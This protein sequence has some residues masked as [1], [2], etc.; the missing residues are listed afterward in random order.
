MKLVEPSTGLTFYTGAFCVLVI[1]AF[2]FLAYA[3]SF[4]VPFL[5]DD[6]NNILDNSTIRDLKDIGRVF[7][8]P[9]SS[10]LGQRPIVNLTLAVNYAMSGEKVWS[11]HLF[12]LLIHTV[13]ALALFGI[14][15]RTLLTERMRDDYHHVAVPLALGSSLIWMLHPVQTQAV[16]YIIQRCE[17]LMGMFFLLTVYCAIRNW[18]SPSKNRWRLLSLISFFLG[19]GSK[20]VIV[21]APFIVLAYEWYF[22]RPATMDILKHSWPLYTGY[23][24]GIVVLAYLVLTGGTLSTGMS[25]DVSEPWLYWQTQPQVIIHYLRIALWPDSLCFDYGWPLVSFREG[26]PTI[27]FLMIILA[28]TFWLFVRRKPA[29]FL[30]FFFFACLIPTSIMPLPDPVFDYRIYLSM[31]A[32][33]AAALIGIHKLCLELNKKI[34][35][36]TKRH[37]LTVCLAVF[38]ILSG[39][40]GLLT[41]KRNQVYSSELTIWTDTVLKRPQ[42]ARAQLN[43]GMA[44]DN[45]GRIHEA[46]RC[47]HEA[48][49][50]NPEYAGA[51]A[52]L[53][54]AL[55]K[56][57][58][59]KEAQVHLGR[60]LEL[61]PNKK[62]S[63]TVY[64]NMGVALSAQGL[65][66]EAIY[67]FKKAVD[68]DADNAVLM[69]N[70]GFAL[71]KTGELAGALNAY[72]KAL[73]IKPEWHLPRQRIETIRL[74][75]KGAGM[76]GTPAPVNPISDRIKVSMLRSFH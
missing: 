11:Y 27:L 74:K 64:S 13:A 2:S 66:R 70:L 17:S 25:K 43:L 14:V 35:L 75:I 71:E 57:G 52:N 58:R 7:F 67:Y 4:R 41:Y 63:A 38:L 46:I 22:V 3:N 32:L 42:N 37:F 53:G 30:F 55:I 65:N 9:A 47:F 29:G 51:Y 39:I 34:P 10:G 28:V 20:E 60:A 31:A 50:L 59:Y 18:D 21:M 48:I 36:L 44:F 33:S 5:F 1:I 15:R 62:A 23:A 8:P 69:L 6:L 45:A 49:R 73:R 54:G 19:V 76:K 61:N 24:A 26:L 56:L 72:E 16:T 12:N 40:L 68:L